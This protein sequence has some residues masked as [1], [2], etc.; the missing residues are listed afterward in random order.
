MAARTPV[1]LLTGY[2]GAGKTTLLARWLRE[3][4]LA[5]AALVINEIGEVGLDDRLLD[6]AVDAASL[7]ANACICCTGL[8]GLEQALSDLWWDALHR[9]RPSFDAVL[10]ETTSRSAKATWARASGCAASSGHAV[11]ALTTVTTPASA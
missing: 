11:V 4:A 8:P 9:R 3:P 10:I 2:L 6:G 1:W 7:L 5:R